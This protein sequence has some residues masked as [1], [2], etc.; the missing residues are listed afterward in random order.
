MKHSVKIMVTMGLAS[1]GS[2][3]R[4][5]AQP[6]PKEQVNSWL[7]PIVAPVTPPTV[8]HLA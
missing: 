8:F 4:A 7:K 2:A 3:N 1:L 5:F 6:L